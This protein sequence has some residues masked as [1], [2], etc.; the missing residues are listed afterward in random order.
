MGEMINISELVEAKCA[1]ILRL[2]SRIEEIEK[3]KRMDTIKERLLK[4][5]TKA[6]NTESRLIRDF[7]AIELDIAKIEK[8][9]NKM[10]G[11]LKKE[12]EKC[13]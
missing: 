12:E 1:A 4:I 11:N 8:K 3:R 7:E 5:L 13:Q 9:I 6:L 10:D 2:F